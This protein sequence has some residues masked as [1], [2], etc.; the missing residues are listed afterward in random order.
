MH[1]P[2]GI[3]VQ[4]TTPTLVVL[5]QPAHS[6]GH[7]TTY[8][9]AMGMPVATAMFQAAHA[10]TKADSAWALLGMLM[11]LPF[12][13]QLKPLLRSMSLQ[14]ALRPL[15]SAPGRSEQLEQRVLMESS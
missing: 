9:V 7:L 10:E 15:A 8:V 5:A 14:R 11:H 1:E 3:G 6:G 2:H 4:D 12:Q 13:P